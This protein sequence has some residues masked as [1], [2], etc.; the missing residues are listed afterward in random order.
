MTCDDQTSHP[1]AGVAVATTGTIVAVGDY[2]ANASRGEVPGFRDTGGAWDSVQVQG[3][4]DDG[5]AG[6][7]LAMNDHLL[8]TG[9]G[10][11]GGSGDTV[12]ATV[13]PT[14]ALFD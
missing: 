5:R 8:V 9:Q 6:T 14:V 7:S 1:T 12:V 4:S 13:Q 3:A 10:V 2:A 11:M